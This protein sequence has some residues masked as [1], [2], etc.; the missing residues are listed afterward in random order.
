MRVEDIISKIERLKDGKIKQ[1]G[2]H[3]LN[4]VEQL[5]K[6]CQEN[7]IIAFIK[8]EVTCFY[9]RI[10]QIDD[11]SEFYTY[12]KKQL[13]KLSKVNFVIFK[14]YKPWPEEGRFVLRNKNPVIL[15]KHMIYPIE[16]NLFAR[17]LTK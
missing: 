12:N 7:S 6:Y 16:D 10:Y 1:Y 2:V 9:T 13:E 3:H 14:G 11:V 15:S 8:S 4:D 17:S 5:I